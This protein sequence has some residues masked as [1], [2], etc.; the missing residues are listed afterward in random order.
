MSGRK[1]TAMGLI[2]E[3]NRIP[4]VMRELLILQNIR[5]RF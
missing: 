5:G 2:L 4:T 1:L 3:N